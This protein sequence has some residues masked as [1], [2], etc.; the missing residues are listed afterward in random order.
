MVIVYL[1]KTGH[2]KTLTGFNSELDDSIFTFFIRDR[3]VIVS[4]I[5]K[6]VKVSATT[7]SEF[8]QYLCL[9]DNLK[10]RLIAP[11]EYSHEGRSIIIDTK[12]LISPNCCN[13]TETVNVVDMSIY[14]MF[15]AT[16]HPIDPCNYFKPLGETYERELYHNGMGAYP[17][18]NLQRRR[19]FV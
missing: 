13:D 16:T 2:I 1:T 9:T 3:A 12:D 19:Y 17:L 18:D 6:G 14:T 7:I 8:E 15:M 4:I 5:Y 11:F 10:P